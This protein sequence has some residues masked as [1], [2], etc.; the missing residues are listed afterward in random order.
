MEPDVKSL[1]DES[2]AN[3]LLK[4]S[5]RTPRPTSGPPISDPTG[6]V[7]DQRPEANHETVLAEGAEFQAVAR[8]AAE[9]IVATLNEDKALAASA[10]QG[11]EPTPVPRVQVPIAEAPP[12]D[13][14]VPGLDPGSK[15][16]LGEDLP[17][18]DAPSRD[19]EVD[20]LVL[21]DLRAVDLEKLET[22]TPLVLKW[23]QRQV[24]RAILPWYRAKLFGG[25][26]LSMTACKTSVQAA[27]D[28]AVLAVRDDLD[29]IQ[30]HTRLLLTLHRTWSASA[31]GQQIIMAAAID[32]FCRLSRLGETAEP[33]PC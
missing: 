8:K 21:A 26:G 28:G 29:F 17:L 5:G 20:N 27:V 16:P 22:R 2:G 23:L 1:L 18:D 4:E 24:P 19:S 6:L 33:P 7:F 10:P 11:H 12:H 30:G 14:V 13:L 25:L 32:E 9:N 15:E 3:A 31:L